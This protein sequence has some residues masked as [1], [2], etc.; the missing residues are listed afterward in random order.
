[1]LFLAVFG[2]FYYVTQHLEFVLGYSALA[3]GV[4]LLPVALSVF[5]GAAPTSI[6]VPRAGLKLTVSAGMAVGTVAMFLL[7]RIGDGSGYSSYVAPMVL[8]GIAI[9]LSLSPATDTIMDAFPEDELGVAGAVNDTS[10]ELGGAL[11]VG[12]LGS[13]LATAYRSSLPAGALAALP[14]HA[15]DAVTSSIGAALAT[16]QQLRATAGT[17]TAQLLTAGADHAFTHAVAHASLVG[18][19]IL[20][21]G[22]IVT[23]FLLPRRANEQ[24]AAP[25][26]AITGISRTP[27]GRVNERAAQSNTLRDASLVDAEP[28]A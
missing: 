6:L 11:G 10:L 27:G 21:A 7:A 9:G 25:K 15:H 19:L 13:T 17:Q 2:A 20:G 18:G 23:L 1:V 24:T 5:A 3:T 4:R 8:L 14:A 28:G 22:T 26:A 16:A 12:I